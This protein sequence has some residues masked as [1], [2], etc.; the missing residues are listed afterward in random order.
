MRL[1]VSWEWYGYERLDA[2]RLISYI[3]TVPQ[4][5]PTVIAQLPAAEREP[6]VIVR[7]RCL[8]DDVVDLLF[9]PKVEHGVEARLGPVSVGELCRCGCPRHRPGGVR[10][11]V[12][13]PA[14]K[15]AGRGSGGLELLFLR[16]IA[17]PGVLGHGFSAG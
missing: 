2:D 9:R 13:R 14:S 17:I 16:A 15:A 5:D 10:T 6:V 7:L 11:D 1:S 8:G 3:R 12:C 4:A